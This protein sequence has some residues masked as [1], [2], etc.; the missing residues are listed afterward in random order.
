[1]DEDGLAG[2]GPRSH[3]DRFVERQ[4]TPPRIVFLR[5]QQGCLDDKDVRAASCFHERVVGTGVTRDDHEAAGPIANRATPGRN[6]VEALNELDREVADLDPPL[7][8]VLDDLEGVVEEPVA[9]ADCR[10]QLVH[11]AAAT[12]RQQDRDAAAREAGPRHQVAQGD[13]VDVVVGVKV[14][15]DDRVELARVA[16]LHQPADHAL[17]AVDEHG[18]RRGFQENPGRGRLRLRGGRACADDRDA[19]HGTTGSFGIGRMVPRP[20]NCLPAPRVRGSCRADDT[21]RRR[22]LEHAVRCRA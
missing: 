6:V 22:G 19:R 12:R 16:D 3:V 21:C 5:A 1:M 11:L 15:D 10:G 9:L 20:R 8:V 13:E 14:A 7:R 2:A 18:G 4:V 17:A